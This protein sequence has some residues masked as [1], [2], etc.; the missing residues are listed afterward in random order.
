MGIDKS[1]RQVGVCLKHLPSFSSSTDHHYHDQNVPWQRVVNAKGVISP[2]FVA[3]SQLFKP[4]LTCSRGPGA[5]ARQATELRRE[6]VRVETGRM[7]EL[8]VDFAGCGWFPNMLP[9]E[10]AELSDSE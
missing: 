9:S 8:S 6:G 4:G 10:E 7:G 1:S 2:R 3:L 5:A